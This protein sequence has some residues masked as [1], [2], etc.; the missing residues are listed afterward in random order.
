MMQ[1]PKKIKQVRQA[2][3]ILSYFKLEWGTLIL[4]AFSG[5]IYNVG[6]VAGPYFEGRLAQSLF[7]VMGGNKD[8]YAM[9]SLVMIYLA[10]ILVVQLMRCI[11]RFYVRRFANNT[12]R[13]MRHMLYNS[14]VN[15]T[16]E[17]R[18]QE[19]IGTLMTK[20][21]SDV[22]ACTE[23]M[24][25]F[26]TEVF[27]TGV[28]L[29]AY[30]AMLVYYDW[31]L[32]LL[33]CGFT[34][35][36]YCI[37]GWLKHY[38]VRYNGEYKKSAERLN[39]ATMDRITGALTYRVYGCEEI[40]DEAYE[41]HLSDYE[42]S[43]II[44]NLWES[45]MQPLYHIISMCGV[46]FILYWGGKNVLGVGFSYWDIAAFTTFLSCFTKMALKSSKAAKLFNAVQKADVSWKR[47]KP[48]MK[49]YIEPSTVSDIP[50][51]E[52][53]NLHVLNLSL[54]GKNGE[55]ILQN[56]SF[57]ATEGEI[58]GITGTI[59]SG[60]SMLGKTLIGELPYRGSI[61]LSNRELSELSLYERSRFISY[62][63][64]QPELM[65]GSIIENIQLGKS[66]TIQDVLQT[67]CLTDEIAG[68]P[69]GMDTLVGSGGIRL[70]GGQQARLA[71][72]RTCY[73]AQHIL[74]L[75]D[76]FSG[77]DKS[78]E[79]EI[80]ESLRELSK[81]RIVILISHRLQLFPKLDRVL[82]LEEG[83]GVFSSHDALMQSN[84]GYANLYQ[85]Q[86]TG[87]DANAV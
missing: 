33:S 56:L 11:K 41:R 86:V 81:H 27:D 72:A 30:F 35:V 26:T 4:V 18:E 7:D 87:G 34:L 79:Q 15:S 37:A 74:I 82:F 77:V 71:L 8:F 55:T 1:T 59:A 48:L 24:R 10:T 64:H 38:V 51:E 47:I 63:G 83:K 22:D 66:G 58:I 23:G 61:Q 42:K 5:I 14:L 49:E 13:N 78:T 32:T 85:A 46:I 75:D 60:K 67:V 17:E 45:T 21:I 84:I 16:H 53:A 9:V 44:A 40:R 3:Q 70:S 62:L 73:N 69:Q 54:E 2:D 50:F 29:L 31:R 25:K 80:F 65:S 52:P 12:S 28:V 20:A 36:A 39:N 43:A 68:M 19:D 57:S 76:P 6:M